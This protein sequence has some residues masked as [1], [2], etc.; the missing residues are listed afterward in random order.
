MSMPLLKG[1][2]NAIVLELI[3]FLY[4]RCDGPPVIYDR[5]IFANKKHRT[6]AQSDFIRGDLAITP[7]NT[8]WFQVP[9]DPATQLNAG[10]MQMM[11][12]A[13]GKLFQ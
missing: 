11:G 5:M 8:G 12:G 9:A 4:Q 6:Y 3:R 2:I 7:C 1:K 13:F 10:A